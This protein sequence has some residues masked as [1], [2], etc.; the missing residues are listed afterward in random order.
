MRPQRLVFGEAPELYDKARPGY[1]GAVVED[2]LSFA[3][4]HGPDG[5]ALEVGAGTG[6]A[7]VAFAPT[8]LDVL[9]L[10]PD[11]AMGAVARRHCQPFAN[12]RIETSGF[13]D[14]PV[15]AGAFDLVFSAQAWHWLDPRVRYQKAAQA[16]VPGGT[17]ALFWHRID[18]HKEPL[19]DELD[20][21]YQRAAP[22][23]YAR[24]P[25][26]PGLSSRSLDDKW[27]AEADASGLFHG[28]VARTHPWSATYTAATLTELLRT[29]S[30]H[31]MLDEGTRADLMNGV[32]E[33]IA[34]HGG[35]VTV[36]HVA[37]LVMAHQRTP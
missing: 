28:A 36:P 25:G 4:L 18:W 9:A 1:S 2:V 32:T 31:R 29:Q 26:F 19:R 5:R 8:G 35:T 13:E 7:T 27:A 30:D 20:D 11:P 14:W 6:K 37:L 33:I 3:G 34:G 24:R 23:L 16:L 22:E 10:E 17:L 21:L 15:Q 12:V